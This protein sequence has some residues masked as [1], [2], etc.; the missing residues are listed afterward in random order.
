MQKLTV[1]IRILF[2]LLFLVMGLNYFFH[3]LM[4]PPL[5]LEASNFMLSLAATGYIL[6]LTAGIQILAGVMLLLNIFSPLALLLLAP[7]IIHILLFHIYLDTAGLGLA[8]GIIV[9]ECFLAL[10]Y[11]DHFSH[12]F[13]K[14]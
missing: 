12:L 13:K 8:I 1:I 6:P 10:R 9:V 11:W 3:F 14:S 2:G 5:S 7:I 4:L